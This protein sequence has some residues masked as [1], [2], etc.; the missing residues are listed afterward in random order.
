ME[1]PVKV[2]KRL[3]KTLR[4]DFE[5]A[6]LI[7]GRRGGRI[8]PPNRAHS[9]DKVT[10]Y[11]KSGRHRVN[12]WF[13][14]YDALI[15]EALSEIQHGQDWTGPM[16]EI[17]VFHG[18][19]AILLD[20]LRQ[21]GEAIVCLDLFADDARRI[22]ERNLRHHVGSAH[23]CAIVSG[24]SQDY[25]AATLAAFAGRYRFYHIDGGHTFEEA[26]HDLRLAPDILTEQGI[27]ALDDVFVSAH[28]DVTTALYSFL[29]EKKLKLFALSNNKGYLCTPD[30]AAFYRDN[31][32][33]MLPNVTAH[34]TR[35]HGQSIVSFPQF[36]A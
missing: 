21:Q 8:T 5:R 29:K 31:L 23:G 11:L 36:I 22:F 10:S 16:M 35:F 13:H 24:N 15:I 25:D 1:N 18:K 19:S 28:P 26:L 32:R 27:V 14:L 20:L 3:H 6:E 12:G 34:P 7:D 30:L 17:G 9:L 2:F 33:G 4:N